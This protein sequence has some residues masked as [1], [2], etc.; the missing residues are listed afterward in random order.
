MSRPRFSSAVGFAC[1]LC[2]G[3]SDPLLPSSWFDGPA[4]SAVLQPW[5]AS[6]F[7]E[8]VG[9]VANTRNATIVPLDLKHASLLSDQYAAPY[10]PPR[11]VATGDQRQLGPLVAWGQ[12]DA[13]SVFAIDFA[14][15]V[16]VE[17]PYIE[18]VSEGGEPQPPSLSAS[19][20]LFVDADDSGSDATIEDLLLR[21]GATTTED[22]TFEFANGAWWA[23]GS[24]SGKQARTFRTGETFNADSR[25]VELRI[26][27][28]PTHGD[29]I[30]LR[31][32]TGLREHAVDG[33]PLSLFR[34]PNQDLLIIGVWNEDADRGELVLWDMAGRTTLGVLELADGGQPWRFAFDPSA[35]TLWV[36]DASLPQLYGVAL[37]LDDFGGSVVT[38]L[39]TDAPVAS[40]AWVGGVGDPEFGDLPFANLYAAPIG[41]N[42]VDVYDLLEER[43][44][45][46]NP[47]DSVIGGIDLNSPVVGLSA[48]EEPVLL[49][50]VSNTGAR[51]S[52]QVVVVTTFDGSIRM[53]EGRTGCLAID[54][55]GPRA[56]AS[57][58]TDSG[59]DFSDN[60]PTSDPVFYT[61]AATLSPISP[62]DCGGVVQ[63]E[64]WTVT[65][66][67]LVGSWEVEGTR[68][69]VQLQRAVENQRFVTDDGAFS[70]LMLS[71]AQPSSDGD[72][73]EFSTTDG[74]LRIS[75]VLR[76]GSQSA[77]PLEL[78]AA[79][80]VFSME[81]GPTGGGW[82]ADRTEIH[83]MVPVTAADFVLRVRLQAWAV[84]VLYD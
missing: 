45:D 63:S 4:E 37:D 13:V 21:H 56:S 46:V 22:W 49:Q 62:L 44:I 39:A 82:D 11:L 28:E 1:A 16:L 43:W 65:Y 19:E 17:A 71:G 26:T 51:D 2:T 33:T 66:D 5:Q 61:D 59:V 3:C 54:G 30:E 6:P 70:F 36:A 78:P 12:G 64:A 75:E 42:R 76:T 80:V 38:T 9:F 69:G 60:P 57:S 58:A 79:P 24:R 8:P 15:G 29:R 53:F 50:S 73:F 41:V 55:L 32:D 67:E 20:P 68:S 72:R 14:F 18:T 77:T 81:Q 25:E 40:V 52:D 7:S 23:F 84:E 48:S 10:L 83:A 34:V 27:G 74:V 35:D 47:L 31:T